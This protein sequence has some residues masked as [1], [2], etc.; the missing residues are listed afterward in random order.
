[1]YTKNYRDRL[2]PRSK[3]GPAKPTFQLLAR[4]VI[5]QSPSCPKPGQ[6]QG[7]QA[8]P[9]LAHHYI[10]HLRASVNWKEHRAECHQRM[11]ANPE[12]T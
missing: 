5:L 3:P 8:K 4:L 2:W 10:N 7:F 9:E 12:I 11:A 6:S 1:M